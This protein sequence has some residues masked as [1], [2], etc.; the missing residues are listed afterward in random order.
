MEENYTRPYAALGALL[1]VIGLALVALLAWPQLQPVERDA[2][3][4]WALA[5]VPTLAPTPAIVVPPAPA[6]APAAQPAPA[7]YVE[8]NGGSVTIT[9]VD[10]NVCISLDCR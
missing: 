10:I 8:N 1:L 7:L 5:P 4:P 6:A 9:N 2:P 3:A